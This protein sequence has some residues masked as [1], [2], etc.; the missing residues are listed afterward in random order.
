MAALHQGV[1]IARH[2][3]GFLRILHQGQCYKRSCEPLA[4]QLKTVFSSYVHT[5]LS[6]VTMFKSSGWY[7]SDTWM[8]AFKLV[9][10]LKAA[11]TVASLFRGLVRTCYWH[12]VIICAQ[13]KVEFVWLLCAVCTAGLRHHELCGEVH[14]RTAVVPEAPPRLLHLHHQHRPQ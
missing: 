13:W 3:K 7:G 4:F 1:H 14:A 5:S 9:L 10:L 6:L 12:A 2:A 8:N 11:E